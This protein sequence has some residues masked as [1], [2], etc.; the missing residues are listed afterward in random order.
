M[1]GSTPPGENQRAVLLAWLLP[2][3][4]RKW[5]VT[6]FIYLPLHPLDHG[7]WNAPVDN[8]KHTLNF[9]CFQCSL[10]G[11]GIIASFGR[12][13][14]GIVNRSPSYSSRLLLFYVKTK[15]RSYI[16]ERSRCTRANRHLH[17]I[18]YQL[19]V[20]NAV[21][22]PCPIICL[23]NA[24]VNYFLDISWKQAN[25]SIICPCCFRVR[26]VQKC[27]VEEETKGGGNALSTPF[28]SRVARS[29]YLS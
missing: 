1:Y 28:S 4:R 7:F 29:Y 13:T 10:K 25:F 24:Q 20:G 6:N 21:S 19:T 12:L 16:S 14:K 8:R 27:V 3:T 18:F 5:L 23:Y 17:F 15:I 2:R 22:L 26:M 9:L 11:G